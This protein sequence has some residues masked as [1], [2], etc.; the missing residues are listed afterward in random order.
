MLL[1]LAAL[2]AV[3]AQASDTVLLT[4]EEF[5]NFS[6]RYYERP[7]PDL[8]GRAT[9]CNLTKGR[10]PRQSSTVLQKRSWQR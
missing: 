5:S 7:R 10:L 3:S 8:L 4:A 9:F 2:T 1:L 6:M